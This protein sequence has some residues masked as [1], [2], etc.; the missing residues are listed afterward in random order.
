[1]NDDDLSGWALP[2][3]NA[4]TALAGLK[5]SLR[6]L[7]LNERQ[8]VFEQR[9]L[10]VVRVAVVDG[11][12]Q[13]ERVKR[14]SRSSPEWLGSTLKDG[15]AVRHFTQSLKQQLASWSDRDD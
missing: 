13:A 11:V 4:D 7:G 1:M 2:A 5:R 3:F 15:A 12:L 6:E 10:A 9:G 14:P 8:G